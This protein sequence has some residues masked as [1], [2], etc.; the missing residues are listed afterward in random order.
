M[1]FESMI[2]GTRFSMNDAIAFEQPRIGGES[3]ISVSS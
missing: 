2:V 3:C 1:F